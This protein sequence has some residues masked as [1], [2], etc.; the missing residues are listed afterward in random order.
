MI[1]EILALLIG[2]V[3]GTFTGL[4]PGIHVNLISVFLLSISP[5]LLNYVSPIVLVIF[6]VAMSIT[7]SFL[8]F[9]PSIFLGA[10]DEDSFLA[11]LPG[12]ELLKKGK[13]YEAVV[14]ALYGSASALFI[15]LICIPIFLFI[16][17]TIHNYLA[18]LIPYIL[19]FLSLFLILREENFLNSFIVFFLSA[20]LGLITFKLPIKEPLLPL[21][22]G[23]FACSSL[24]LSL[25][26]ESKK[27]AKQSMPPLKKIKLKKSNFFKSIFSAS[28]SA[29]LCSL[30]PGIGSGHAATLA[31]EII[32]H[33]SRS[34]IFLTGAINTIIMALSFI[35]VYSINKTR[36]GSAVAVKEI[37]GSISFN[38]L[39]V[40]IMAIFVTGI[41]SFILGIKI[42][43]IVAKN[44]SKINYKALSIITMFILLAVNII[45]SNLLGLIILVTATAL[46]IFTVVS[47][48]RRINLMGCLLIPAIVFYL[49]N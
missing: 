46:G 9:I 12:H 6:I 42:T 14:L 21:L 10:P 20:F 32:P 19:I 5:A 27:L 13:G 24:I 44:I 22:T 28:I 37:L 25:K 2:L 17:P 1:A 38:N 16:L 26:S 3:A 43:K 15:V 23:L 11:V 7:H 35:A 18:I 33:D 30:F 48:S 31:S 36:S 47:N 41:F 45:F 49:T 39:I 34:F 4:F 40:I 29:P 8:D